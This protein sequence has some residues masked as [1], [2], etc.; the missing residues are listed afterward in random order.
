MA[1]A[2][3]GSHTVLMS[4]NEPSKGTETAEE[5]QAK[6]ETPKKLDKHPFSYT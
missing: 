6:H 1:T 3:P 5:K 4:Q 2:P